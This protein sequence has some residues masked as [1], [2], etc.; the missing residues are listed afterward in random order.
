VVFVPDEVE[1][2][3]E[4]LRRLRGAHDVVFTSGG[5]GPTH[6]DLTVEA[7][8]RALDVPVVLD[9][10]LVALIEGVYGSATTDAHRLMARIPAGAELVSGTDIRWP[11]V[12]A[13]GVWILPG[14]PELFRMKLALVREVLR[15][16][17]PVYGRE[18]YT[19]AEE[20]DFKELLDAVVGAHPAVEIGSYPKW[21][22][23]RYRTK[24]TFDAASEEDAERACADL[25]VRLGAR[26]VE[27]LPR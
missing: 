8:A 22:D 25:R 23:E 5:V 3:A 20:V 26:V 12:V 4:E 16:P 13:A 2:I 21:F 14:V 10:T 11:T 7:V 19:T 24:V 9:R 18:L 27:F 1:T 17:V 15:G 6:D